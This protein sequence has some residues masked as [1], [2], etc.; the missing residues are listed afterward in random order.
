[1]SCFEAD[2]L[3]FYLSMSDCVTSAKVDDRTCSVTVHHDGNRDKIID[4][5]KKYD[6]EK[7]K[8]LLPEHTGRELNR[9]YQE[10]LVWSVIGHYARKLFLARAMA[11]PSP[12]PGAHDGAGGP[13]R[14]ARPGDSEAT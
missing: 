5:L 4:M 13:A 3:E 10:K 8:E 2:V 11:G 1:M 14:P 6:F 7:N 12:G 9:K